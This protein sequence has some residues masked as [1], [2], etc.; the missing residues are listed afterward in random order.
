MSNESTIAI[1]NKKVLMTGIYKSLNNL[2]PSI[3]SDIFQKQENYYSL[4]NRRS[5]VSK[6][7]FATTCGIDTIIFQ[8]SSNLAISS[9]VN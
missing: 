3:I 4:R 8:R 6:R 2:L 9:L 5:L 1:E 7:K